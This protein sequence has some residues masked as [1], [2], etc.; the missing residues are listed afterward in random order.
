MKEKLSSTAILHSYRA[1][2]VHVI[3][4]TK[5]SEGKPYPSPITILKTWMLAPKV[6]DMEDILIK[7]VL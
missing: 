1:D 3:G 7:L 2:S 6:K 4:E 5:Q